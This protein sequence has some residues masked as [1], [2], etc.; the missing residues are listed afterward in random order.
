M[1]DSKITEISDYIET[2]K[3]DNGRPVGDL[4]KFYMYAAVLNSV[5]VR[6][7]SK[8]FTHL[9]PKDN[10]HISRAWNFF[11]GS[12]LEPK[13][14]SLQVQFYEQ[15][16]QY[17]EQFKHERSE[18]DVLAVAKKLVLAYFRKGQLGDLAFINERMLS[19]LEML[20]GSLGQDAE[21]YSNIN[22]ATMQTQIKTLLQATKAVHTNGF[23]CVDNG[24]KMGGSVVIAVLG[25][26]AVVSLTHVLLGLL[27]MAAGGFCA[28]V[29]AMQAE[30]AFFKTRQSIQACTNETTRICELVS[31][32]GDKVQ[33]SFIIDTILQPLHYSSVTISEQLSMD[34]EKT[35]FVGR[36]EVTQVV[37][38]EEVRNDLDRQYGV[39][40]L[41]F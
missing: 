41:T 14:G 15:V 11:N 25:L 10:R 26:I 28:Y 40:R 34:Y 19:H 3:D 1:F 5:T 29:F 32:S 8:S 39:T 23:A 20:S 24:F 21:L 36:Q 4:T 27:A 37:P 13:P 7:E 38:V 33:K 16:T 17:R 6:D 2:L 35:V 12:Q 18:F 22:F 30:R 31:K 9:L